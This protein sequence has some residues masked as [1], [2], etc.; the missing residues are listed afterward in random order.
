MPNP[1]YIDSETGVLTDPEAWVAL[2]TTILGSNAATITFKSGFD[3]TDTDVG[4]VQAWDQYMD[5]II[6]SYARSLVSGASG[7]Y[8]LNINNDTTGHY[9][10]QYFWGNGATVYGG[11]SD[12]QTYVPLGDMTAN[13]AGANIF[14]C[15]ITELFD[16]NSSRPKTV[17]SRTAADRDGSGWIQND[18]VMW[19]SKA[20]ITELDITASA[21]I[22]TGSMFSLFGVLPRMVL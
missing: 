3:D 5:L 9:R 11:S 4:G 14:G 8:Y 20:A 12:T 17:I 19:P 15:N 13:L 16:I 6:F 22:V 21:N 1:S 7:G 2:N 18:M 10:R